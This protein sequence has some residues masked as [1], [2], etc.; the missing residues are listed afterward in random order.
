MDPRAGISHHHR[1]ARTP[2]RLERIH[3][4]TMG[5]QLVESG[6]QPIKSEKNC[7]SFRIKTTFGI[8]E[9]EEEEEENVL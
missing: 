5:A 7:R 8:F 2:I 3:N 1:P 9:E 4:G 6:S